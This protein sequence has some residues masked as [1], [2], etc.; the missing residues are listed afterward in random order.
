MTEESLLVLDETSIAYNVV[1]QGP[2]LF[3]VGAP[4]G[5]SGFAQLAAY[6]SDRY[7]VVTH[8]PR[9]IGASQLANTSVSPDPQRRAADVVALAQSLGVERA[10]FFGASGGAVTLLDLIR[11]R[12]DLS[13]RVVIHEA[14]TIAPLADP[15]LAEAFRAC[16][17]L[18]AS[19]PHEAFQRFLDL[20]NIMH[21]TGPDDAMP[22]PV[23]APTMPADQLDRLRYELG[24]MA[25]PTLY[26]EPDLSALAGAD[27][28]ITAG[29]KSHGQYPRRATEALAAQLRQPVHDMPGN[30]LAPSTD[31]KGFATALDLLLRD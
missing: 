1:G 6:L 24:R 23:Q 2:W 13:E 17:A 15:A 25:G 19:D 31:P 7:T 3:L 14:P 10:C 22:P 12:R 16:F 18:A 26:Y 9:G 8:D 30:H 29:V 28:V 11:Q 4:V 27:L 21:S 5:M 20:T